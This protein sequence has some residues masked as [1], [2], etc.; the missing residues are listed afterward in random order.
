MKR[1]VNNLIGLAKNEV[2][3]LEKKSK[4]NLNSK[5]ANA[6]KNN[7]TKYS[8]VF[9]VN[10]CY[11]CCYFVCWLFYMLCG[12]SK[13][14]AKKMLCGCLTGACETLRQAFKK[15]GRYS[16]TPKLGAL[17]F[18][19][20]SRHAGAN[21]IALVV[22]LNEKYIWTTEGNT[23]GANGVIDNGGGVTTKKYLRTYS[24][25]LGYGYPIY[26]EE[27]SK[28][29][30]STSNVVTYYKKYTGKSKKIN[31]VFKSIGV[32]EKYCNTWSSRKPVA[33]KNGIK[34]YKGT[35]D[36]NLKLI[37][38]AKSGKLKKV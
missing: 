15:A 8:E 25:I 21:H 31:E 10:G 24:K 37:S 29:A 35:A 30:Q 22:K 17:V 27:A 33:G 38:L 28:H 2:G 4:K 36:Q 19:S 18:F 11:W 12:K 16:S 23:S 9:G 7:Y 1:T 32:P 3:Y 14:E 20:G 34:D 13:T 6:G 26:E 5:T